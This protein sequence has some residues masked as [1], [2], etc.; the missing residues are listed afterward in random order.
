MQLTEFLKAPLQRGALLD[1]VLDKE[2]DTELALQRQL[3]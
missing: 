3:P 2:I 1:D